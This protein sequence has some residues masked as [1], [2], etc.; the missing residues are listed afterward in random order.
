MTHSD[1]IV[2]G[3]GLSGLSAARKLHEAGKSVTVLEARDRVGGK[4]WSVRTKA[5]GNVELG[6]AWINEHTQPT[7]TRLAEEAGNRYFEQNIDGSSIVYHASSGAR[8]LFPAATVNELDPKDPLYPL[9]TQLQALADS[10]DIADVAQTPNAVQLDEMSA[11]TWFLEA[12][13]TPEQIHA[14]L[15]PVVGAI[16]GGAAREIS[17]L[18]LLHYIKSCGGWVSLTSDNRKG[19]Q[20]QRTRNGNQSMSVYLASLL[21]A[22][23]VR[24]EQPVSSVVRTRDIVVVTTRAGATFTADAAILAL[25]TPLYSNI[26][27]EPPLPLLQRQAVERS[28]VGYYCK[29]ILAYD[30]PWWYEAGYSGSSFLPDGY[31]GITLDSSDGVYARGLDVRGMPPRQYSLTCFITD[32]RGL[33]WSQLSRAERHAAVIAEVGAAFQRPQDA[34]H[35]AEIFELEWINEEWSRGAPVALYPPGQFLLLQKAS[36]EPTDRLFFA[37]TENSPVWKGYM[38]GA[39]IAGRNA[40]GQAIEWLNGPGRKGKLRRGEVVAG[41][42]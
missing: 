42:L 24:L 3:G 35:P 33:R 15:D 41:K 22:G 9:K 5:G 11:Y 28:F 18:F 39:V 37:G 26:R 4:T 16:W 19:G 32:Q 14:E 6:A 2:I 21:P 10:V 29:V 25:P 13:A 40:A 36:G 1:I 34:A 31:V 8:E 20:Y 30:R 27:F 7:I 12:G 17:F 38:E 23:S